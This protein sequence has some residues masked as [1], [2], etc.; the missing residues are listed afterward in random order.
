MTDTI[1]AIVASVACGAE[2]E[3]GIFIVIVFYHGSGHL[4]EEHQTE[5]T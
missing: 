2:I 1:G 4:N 5:R 3:I